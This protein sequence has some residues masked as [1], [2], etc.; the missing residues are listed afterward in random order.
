MIFKETKNPRVVEPG[1]VVFSNNGFLKVAQNK[2]E[3]TDFITKEA[4]I[5]DGVQSMV[6]CNVPFFKKFHLLKAFKQWRYEMRTSYYTKTR[7][8][9]AKNF[10]FARPIFMERY[11]SLH[12]RVS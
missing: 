4:F 5:E 9:L 6:L 12:K 3:M 2:N 11:R 10:I 7:E 8:R 1:N